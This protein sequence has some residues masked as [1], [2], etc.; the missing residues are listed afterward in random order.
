METIRTATVN[1]ARAAWM[2]AVWPSLVLS[3]AIALDQ[4]T[5]GPSISA[6]VLT[7]LLG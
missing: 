7:Y 5:R 6:M 3:V 1:T 4:Y 2:R